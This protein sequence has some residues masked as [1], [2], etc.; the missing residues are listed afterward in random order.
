VSGWTQA[1][2]AGFSRRL[3]QNAPGSCLTAGG[4]MRG[5]AR[6]EVAVSR[7]GIGRLH[8]VHLNDRVPR[9]LRHG[10]IR[11]DDGRSGNSTNDECNSSK[12]GQHV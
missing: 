7:P 1:F 4:S 12:N 11:R 2:A 9:V 6:L 10:M 8:R 5:N 3:T